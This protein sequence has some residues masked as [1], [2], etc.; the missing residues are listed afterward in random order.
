MIRTSR[1][2]ASSAVITL[3]LIASW[4]LAQP[5]PREE[6]GTVPKDASQAVE[7]ECKCSE[8]QTIEPMGFMD[9]PNLTDAQEEQIQNLRLK[10][11]KEMLPIETEIRIKEIELDALWQGEKFDVKQIIA[12]VKEIGELRNKLELARVNQ[13]IEIYKILTPEQRKILRRGFGMEKGM[14]REM[15][16]RFR[17]R[18]QGEKR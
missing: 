5:C 3:M 11:L 17:F 8:Q 12:K 6:K 10:H 1:I 15:R 14:W 4:V 9:L 16:K 7:C 18:E 2:A 13:R